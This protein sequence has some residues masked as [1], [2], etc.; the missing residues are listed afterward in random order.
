MSDRD[1]RNLAHATKLV[2]SATRYF[3]QVT[4]WQAKR[5]TLLLQLADLPTLL[6][7]HRTRS[8]RTYPENPRILIVDQIPTLRLANAIEATA[9]GLYSVAE[10]AAS[11]GNKASRGVVPS[12]FNALRK[13]CEKDPGDGLSAALGD[14]Q[15]YRK[16]REMR[17]EWTHH[18]SIFIAENDAGLPLACVRSFRRP[19]DKV[20]F[21]A[22]NFACT[23]EEFGDW[24]RSALSTLD[25]FA[26]YLLHSY[27]LKQFELDTT[28]NSVALDP[29]GMPIIG[30]GNRF[31]VE[32]ITIREYLRRGGIEAHQ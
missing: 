8:K 16:I 20:E 5:E 12:S 2:S 19:S 15:W 23:V 26:G 3:E 6:A 28:F 14:F 7:A 18:S 10:I 22:S 9:N 11:F 32:T 17:T 30:E 4:E 24:V 27:V 25:S 13:K 21:T 29:N 1:F 31:R